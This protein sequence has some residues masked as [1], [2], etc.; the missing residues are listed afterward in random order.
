M[1]G[2]DYKSLPQG[3]GALGS[4]LYLYLDGA[5]MH[6]VGVEADAVFKLVNGK[7]KT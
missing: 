5:L 4:V 6:L 7:E 1:K 2:F 3:S